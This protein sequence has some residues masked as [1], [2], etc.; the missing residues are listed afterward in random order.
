LLQARRGK[1]EFLS[2]AEFFTA[3]VAAGTHTS[4]TNL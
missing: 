3:S 2:S 1:G 4:C